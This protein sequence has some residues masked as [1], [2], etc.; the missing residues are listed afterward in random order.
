MFGNERDRI[1]EIRGR[2]GSDIVQVGVDP[3]GTS[4]VAEREQVAVPGVDFRSPW[5]RD[6]VSLSMEAQLSMI[7]SRAAYRLTLADLGYTNKINVQEIRPGI[8][9]KIESTGCYRLAYNDR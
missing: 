5:L 9:C 3:A 1:Q 6:R 2:S 4:G 7:E 8:Y